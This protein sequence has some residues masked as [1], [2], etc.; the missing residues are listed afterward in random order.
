MLFHE[1]NVHT[2]SSHRMP[3]PF[4]HQAGTGFAPLDIPTENA[5][6]WLKNEKF[7]TGNVDYVG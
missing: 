3:H 5:K 1:R 4:L 7:H 2:M 6:F